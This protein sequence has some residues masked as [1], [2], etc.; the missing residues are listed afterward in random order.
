MRTEN[1]VAAN[2]AVTRIRTRVAQARRYVWNRG[3]AVRRSLL[4]LVVVA[5]L[6]VLG[7]WATPSAPGRFLYG[8]KRFSQDDLISIER[9]L[10]T[11]NIGFEVVEGRVEVASSD[12]TQ[13]QEALSH[14]ELGP[15]SIREIRKRSG[16]SHLFESLWER[17]ERIAQ[18]RE[19]ILEAMIGNLPGVVSAH[20]FI[21]RPRTGSLRQAAEPKALVHLQT[22]GDRELRPETIRSIQGLVSSIPGLKQ[23]AVTIY[24][25]KGHRYFG[26]DDPNLG[27]TFRTRAREEELSQQIQEQLDWIKGVRVM[28]HLTPVAMPVPEVAPPPVAESAEA[29]SPA[30]FW[31]GVNRPT[32]LEQPESKPKA[33]PRPAPAA[34]PPTPRERLQVLVLIPRSYYL[35]VSQNNEPSKEQLQPI[36][37]RT[38]INIRETIGH[39]ARRDESPEIVIDTYPDVPATS[40][41]VV[42]TNVSEPLRGVPWWALAA[43]GGTVL[44]MLLVLGYRV[45]T[46]YRPV[47]RSTIEEPSLGRFTAAAVSESRGPGP[48]D[49]VRE[50]IRLN[51]KA[52]ASILNRWIGQGGPLG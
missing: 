37:Q 14:L 16:E 41:P 19:K 32:D 1:P 13:A 34:P 29:P 12:L 40:A 30:E 22:D 9:T 51:P 10:N 35:K 21:N 48:S 52:A 44:G 45:V 2:A 46:S 43:A 49:R 7:Y 42:P 33:R 25:K 31:V 38:E 8:G 36:V 50:L 11:K 39:L 24:D 28:V 23:D 27:S 6:V 17:E 47:S 20:V 4:V 3:P 5:G 18:D 26:A 15:N